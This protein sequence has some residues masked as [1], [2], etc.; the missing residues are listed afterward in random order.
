LQLT[1][2]ERIGT[3][4]T[5]EIPNLAPHVAPWWVI[6]ILGRLVSSDFN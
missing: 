6:E 5:L 2:Q 1:S 4:I 3:S